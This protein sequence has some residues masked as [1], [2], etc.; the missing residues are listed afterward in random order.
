MLSEK[1]KRLNFTQQFHSEI[2]YGCFTSKRHQLALINKD[3]QYASY[4]NKSTLK[5]CVSYEVR[6]RD[7]VNWLYKCPPDSRVMERFL[8]QTPICW[9]W[10]FV[11]LR[12]VYRIGLVQNRLSQTSVWLWDSVFTVWCFNWITTVDGLLMNS[13][14][15]LGVS[16][17][18]LLQRVTFYFQYVCDTCLS[19][20]LSL[21]WNTATKEVSEDQFTNFRWSRRNTTPLRAIV[22]SLH[23]VW[24]Y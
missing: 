8:L 1:N 13:I 2:S 3:I 16:C 10:Q 24:T 14:L 7:S 15:P 17:N 4:K 19:T 21:P 22:V 5:G 11:L 20:S 9:S 6:S 23:C 12:E 18:S